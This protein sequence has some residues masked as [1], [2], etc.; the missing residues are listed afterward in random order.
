MNNNFPY[1]YFLTDNVFTLK[2]LEISP[3]DIIKANL[4]PKVSLFSDPKYRDL[5]NNFIT[6]HKLDNSII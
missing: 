1:D 4:I 5:I 3:I 2:D 6:N